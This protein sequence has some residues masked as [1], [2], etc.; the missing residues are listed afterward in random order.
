MKKR[1]FPGKRYMILLFLAALALVCAIF[2]VTSRL[3]TLQDPQLVSAILSRAIECPVNIEK[4]SL[5]PGGRLILKNVIIYNPYALNREMLNA[6]L[7]TAS[8][9]PWKIIMGK[10][11]VSLTS[12]ELGD[13]TLYS[14]PDTLQWLQKLQ[15][16]WKGP[17]PPIIIKS[18]TL[19][20]AGFPLL[21]PR[22]FKN[23][24][25][26]LKP[27]NPRWECVLRG[28][29]SDLLEKWE[30]L[31]KG[32]AA[33]TPLMK[34][35]GQNVES[36]DVFDEKALKDLPHL[37]GKADFQ[38]ELQEEGWKGTVDAVT[39]SASLF[40]AGKK[41]SLTDALMGDWKDIDLAFSLKGDALL[42]LRGEAFHHLPGK[43]LF[44]GKLG[45]GSWEMTSSSQHLSYASLTFMEP[46]LRLRKNGGSLAGSFSSKTGKMDFQPELPDPEGW[47]GTVEIRKLIASL[48]HADRKGSLSDAFKG[49]WKDIHM[50][51]SQEKDAPLELRGETLH[52]LLGKILFTGK[53]GKDSWEM[54]SS[55]Q[56]LSYASLT[57]MEPKLHLRKKGGILAGS[58]SSRTGKME[59]FLLVAPHFTFQEHEGLAFAGTCTLFGSTATIHGKSS[60]ES[61]QYTTKIPRFNLKNLSAFHIKEKN[62]S[63]VGNLEATI[64][65]GNQSSRRFSL[66]SK[67]LSWA[68]KKLPRIRVDGEQK[69]RVFLISA[70]RIFTG[71]RPI[72]LAG[73][74]DPEKQ[75]CALTGRI[76]DSSIPALI[77]MVGGRTPDIQG[78]LSG[79][80]AIS[81]YLRK[82]QFQFNGRILQ[83]VYKGR[84]MGDGTLKAGGT[85]Q[86]I[87]GRLDMDR[88]PGSGQALHR[89]TW[90]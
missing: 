49:E 71:T 4:V 55:L 18:G 46:Q 22:Q 80:L 17:R 6:P 30:L 61:M 72:L 84:N 29:S 16:T 67:N 5:S 62:L 78:R 42:E 59:E 3:K 76:N 8:F 48:L 74:M 36:S 77:D 89:P 26:T 10:A 85:S 51:F 65:R 11:E 38:A 27:G 14:A 15:A 88:P 50:T 81:G 56:H 20:I 25:G 68:R 39:L 9:N 54:T 64:T 53:M 35:R 41:G 2:I 33:G 23:I 43:V 34:I 82:P 87:D 66:E 19:E 37:K 70:L 83:L 12:V 79:A 52:S 45:K 44:T 40:L 1:Y 24:Q 63:G 90:R 21:L 86:A 57:F 7:I 75:T 28:T 13:P 73:T 58:L 60:G 31:G 47:K 69:N 32:A